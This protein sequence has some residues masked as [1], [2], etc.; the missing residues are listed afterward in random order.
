MTNALPDFEADEALLTGE[1]LPV[2]KKA[3][4]VFNEDEDT[5]VGDR[6]NIAYSSSSVTKGRAKGVVVRGYHLVEW[7]TLD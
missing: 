5:P 6:I 2:A 4:A 1:S 3:D 7:N